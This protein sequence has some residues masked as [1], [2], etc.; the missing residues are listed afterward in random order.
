[1]A[2]VV[3]DALIGHSGNVGMSADGFVQ[4][5]AALRNLSIVRMLLVI[6]QLANVNP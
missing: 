6:L 2:Q 1:L 3:W 5:H 4:P